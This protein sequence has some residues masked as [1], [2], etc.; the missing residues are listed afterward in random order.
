MVHDAEDHA[1]EDT[2]RR[3]AVE[4]RNQLD[5]LVY[6]TEKTLQENRDNLDAADIDALETALKEG[7]EALE[8]EDVA[9]M[10]QA[11]DTI[12]QASHK[13]AEAMYKNAADTQA[14]GDNGNQPGTDTN[15]TKSK[16]GDV[17]DAE[18][19]DVN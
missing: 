4:T 10:E 17:V 2:D 12:T 13:L 5:S 15:D 8:G 7:K 11:R 3:K 14:A 18:F 1:Q 16:E 9:V 19:E 6:Q